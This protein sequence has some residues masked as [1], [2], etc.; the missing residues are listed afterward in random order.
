M[1]KNRN[2]LA[3]DASEFQSKITVGFT[4]VLKRGDQ[5][6]REVRPNSFHF[7]N[8]IVGKRPIRHRTT[9]NLHSVI[10]N[11]FWVDKNMSLHSKSG[12]VLCRIRLFPTMISKIKWFWSVLNPLPLIPF[13]FQIDWDKMNEWLGSELGSRY[14]NTVLLILRPV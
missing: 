4:V 7:W 13:I 14:L 9:L 10:F 5:F 12:F 3:P 11:R 1:A 6:L 8:I 2:L